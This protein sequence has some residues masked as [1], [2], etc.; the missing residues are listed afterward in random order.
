MVLLKREDGIDLA[1]INSRPLSR[2]NGS[3]RTRIVHRIAGVRGN[4]ASM[5]SWGLE[6]VT[7]STIRPP[8]MQRHCLKP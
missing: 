3:E 1:G 4:I 6:Q 2:N 8:I 7:I 5:P